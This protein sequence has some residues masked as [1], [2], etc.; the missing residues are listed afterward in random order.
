LISGSGLGNPLVWAAWKH[1]AV[2][3]AVSVVCWL[4]FAL[5]FHSQ[6]GAYTS[7][8]YY[9]PAALG[10]GMTALV[11]CLGYL[12]SKRIKTTYVNVFEDRVSGM[13]ADKDFTITKTLYLWVGWNKA[14]FMKLT[15]FDFAIGEITS[16][17]LASDHAVVINAAGASCKCFV[18][19]GPEILDTLNKKIQNHRK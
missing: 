2:V 10:T 6:T 7:S 19:N 15:A 5:Y 17:S 12:V 3:A 16:V 8:W 13:A 11:F 14:R 9:I 1:T 4:I 18:S